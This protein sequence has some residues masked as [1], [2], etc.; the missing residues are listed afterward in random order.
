MTV[1]QTGART[2]LSDTNLIPR[3]IGDTINMIDWQNAPLL[4]LLGTNAESKFK[5]LNWPSTKA[6]IIEDTMSPFTDALAE[7]DDGAAEGELDVTS[8]HGI[9]FRQGD[10]L[11]IGA[12]KLLVTAVSTDTL[13]VVRGIGDTSGTAHNTLEPITIIGRA[14]PEGADPTFGHTTTTTSPYNYSQIISE[15]V[16]ITKTEAAI[17][18]YGVQDAMDYQV[19]KLFKNG[20]RMGKL[21]QLLQKSFYYGERVIRAAAPAYGFMG[22]FPVFVTTNVTALSSAP[23]QKS[24]IHTKMRAIVDAGGECDLLVTGSWG[25]EKIAAMYESTI[26]TQRTERTGGGEI[27]TIVTPM[28][29]VEVV[30]DWM[31]PAGYAYFINTSKCGWLTVRPFTSSEI[32]DEGDYYVTDVV[33]EFSFMV[34]NEKSHGIISGF[35]TTT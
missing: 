16:K 34:A 35:S 12:E 32:R 15:A 25:M 14:M 1:G 30:F 5:L 8:G 23:L 4:Q 11:L 13:S 9:Y 21:A 19:A 27:T 28:G 29:K 22:G 10:I 33:G 17:A 18:H 2:S 20:G 31:C 24:D 7:A 6:E 26:S 3:S